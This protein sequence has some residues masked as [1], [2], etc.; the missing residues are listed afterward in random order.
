MHWKLVFRRGPYIHQIY[1]ANVAP[2]L[3]PKYVP[4][5]LV[6]GEICY[7]TILQGFNASLE[8]EAKKRTLSLMVSK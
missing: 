3:F 7:Q 2:H 4:D 1:G 8:K 6:M 5:R